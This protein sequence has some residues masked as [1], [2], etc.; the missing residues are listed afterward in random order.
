MNRIYTL[1]LILFCSL[2][3]EAQITPVSMEAGYA[4]QTFVNLIDGSITSV[5]ADSWDLAF[6][7]VGSQDLG[8]SLNEGSA[9]GGTA[10]SL[11]L[12][13]DVD[14]STTI[15]PNTLTNIISND[16]T[17]WDNGALNSVNDDQNPLDF[18]WGSYDPSTMVVNGDKTFVLG[19]R[20]GS[21]KKFMIE[22]L[23]GGIYTIK[24]A[25]LDGGSEEIS[26]VNKAD[27]PAAT[28]A[29]FSFTS[30][31]IISAPDSWDILF[32]RYETMVPDGTGGFAPYT[33]TGVLSGYGVETAVVGGIVPDD[34]TKDDFYMNYSNDL[35]GTLDAIG[36]DWKQYTG[37]WDIATDRVYFVKN[38]NDDVFKINFIDFEGSSTGITILDRELLTNTTSI[39]HTIEGVEEFNV[40]PNPVQDITNIS[41]SSDKDDEL[42]IRI[43]DISGKLL[44]DNQSN[45]QR[46]ENQ[47]QLDLNSYAQGQYILLITSSKGLISTILNKL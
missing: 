8:I 15:D 9:F 25:D 2:G 41:F 19:Q 13:E 22:S 31:G 12:A 45:I 47:I 40:F 14:F 24:Y 26:T 7:V 5:S 28:L 18:G 6:T 1:F 21:Y 4:S 42:N 29:F 38:I 39:N 43:F 32:T 46:G 10:L 20:D 36:Y 16:E 33:V 37:T 23:S 34:I 30:G 11:Y 35:D 44:L 3:I 17:S 27:F